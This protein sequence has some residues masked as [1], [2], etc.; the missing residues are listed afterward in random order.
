MKYVTAFVFALS[1]LSGPVSAK[2][3]WDQISETA[4]RSSVFDDIR[5]TAPKSVFETL[6]ETAPR[7]DG[8][9]GEL[10]KNAP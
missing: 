9:F 2:T 6:N 1:V 5:L 7:S 3:L 10:E 8:V 4:P